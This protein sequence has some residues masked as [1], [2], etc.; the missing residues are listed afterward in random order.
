MWSSKIIAFKR[1]SSAG[2][3][4]PIVFAAWR[5]LQ[6]IETVHM[7]RKGRASWVD[8]GDPLAQLQFI[9]ELFGVAI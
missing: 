1:T 4:V 5:T 2:E 6:G 7:I 3:R 8:K 9:D